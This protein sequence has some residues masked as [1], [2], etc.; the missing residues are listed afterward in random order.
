MD[1][2]G[3]FIEIPGTLG[4]F[5]VHCSHL[6]YGCTLAGNSAVLR[7]KIL[8]FVCLGNVGRLGTAAMLEPGRKGHEA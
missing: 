2:F 8:A 3:P 5:G 6:P 1:S 7:P 4:E